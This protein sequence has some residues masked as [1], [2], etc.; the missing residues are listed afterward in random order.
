[1]LRLA[2]PRPTRQLNLSLEVTFI[3]DKRLRPERKTQFEISS[4][5]GRILQNFS[6]HLE[7]SLLL[8]RMARI[9]PPITIEPLVRWSLRPCDVI[10][11]GKWIIKTNKHSLGFGFLFV[12]NFFNCQ[13][14]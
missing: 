9:P 8:N 1:M 6:F 5:D 3:T 14:L 12:N 13:K 7:S 2:E 11:S 10:D 4:P